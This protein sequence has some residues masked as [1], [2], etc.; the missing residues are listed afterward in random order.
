MLPSEAEAA[1]VAADEVGVA[2]AAHSSLRGRVGIQFG[3]TERVTV[4][5]NSDQH[6]GDGEDDAERQHQGG[7]HDRRG[8]AA[9]I[10]AR[11]AAERGE[12]AEQGVEGEP[13]PDEA[14]DQAE[15][16]QLPSHGVEIRAIVS[17]PQESGAPLLPPAS[18]SIALGPDLENWHRIAGRSAAQLKA[19]RGAFSK[20]EL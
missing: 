18:Y 1:Q 17:E 19:R 8:A 11:D 9:G 6:A 7:R 13:G 5:R 16:S 4:T 14:D 20:L 3:V 12:Q 2:A 15:R 10:E